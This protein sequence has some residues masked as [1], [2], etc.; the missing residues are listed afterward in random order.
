MTSPEADRYHHDRHQT[1]PSPTGADSISVLS[2]APSSEAQ[3]R[4]DETTDTI[5]TGMIDLGRLL[6]RIY[7]FGRDKQSVRG[8]PLRLPFD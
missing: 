8:R 2:H 3:M 1:T 4:P 5:R 6:S 7:S